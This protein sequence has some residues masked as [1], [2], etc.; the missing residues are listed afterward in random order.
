MEEYLLI[1]S[2]EEVIGIYEESHKL[3]PLDLRSEEEE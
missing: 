2:G 3:Y 1:T